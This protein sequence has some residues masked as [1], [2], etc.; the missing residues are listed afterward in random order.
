MCYYQIAESLIIV[1]PKIPENLLNG[2]I[3]KYLLVLI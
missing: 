3:I 2:E 1:G